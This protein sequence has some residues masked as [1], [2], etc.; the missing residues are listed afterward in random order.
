MSD[1]DPERPP[2]KALFAQLASDTSAF[3]QAELGYLRA[4]AGERWRFAIPALAA[5]GVGVALMIAVMIA[6][7]LGLMIALAPL[8]GSFIAVLIIV[9]AG[10]MIG[11]LLVRWS[12]QRIKAALKRPEDRQ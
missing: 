8:T 11:A 12:S 5:M 4:Q 10:L 2:V 7:P 3:A 6:L 1:T 9:V